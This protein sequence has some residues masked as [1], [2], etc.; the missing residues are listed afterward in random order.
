MPDV[1]FLFNIWGFCLWFLP[2]TYAV[3]RS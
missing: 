3:N 1:I 2:K